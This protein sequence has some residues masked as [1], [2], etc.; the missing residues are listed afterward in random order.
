MTLN[1]NEE[2]AHS[3]EQSYQTPEIAKQRQC[4]LHSLRLQP[5]NHAI[6]IGCGPGFLTK[7]IADEIGPD[8]RVIGV[9][10]SLPM[11]RLTHTRTRTLTQVKLIQGTLQHLPF[12]NN[13]FDA[14]AC[15]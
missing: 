1:F 7:E 13:T 2:M 12:D 15:I 5:D 14:L 8:G 10:N 3:L 4:T 6:D 9:D 11:L